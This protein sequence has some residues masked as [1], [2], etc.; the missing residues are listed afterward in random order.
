[1][2]LSEGLIGMSF[3]KNPVHLH[4]A[5][6][7]QKAIERVEVTMQRKYTTSVGPS[8]GLRKKADQD[9]SPVLHDPELFQAV[10]GMLNYLSSCSR[11]VIACWEASPSGIH[12]Q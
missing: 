3:L 12:T 4:Q 6:T 11:H 5:K 7:T 10:I 1:M 9:G 2:I 8:H